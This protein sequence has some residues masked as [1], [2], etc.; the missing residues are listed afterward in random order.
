MGSTAVGIAVVLE[1]SE[2]VDIEEAENGPFRTGFP[3]R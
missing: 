2:D 1:G 3:Y